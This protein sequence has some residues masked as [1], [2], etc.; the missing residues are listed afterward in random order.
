MG[1]EN[2]L[3]INF[4]NMLFPMV[5]MPPICHPPLFSGNGLHR[6]IY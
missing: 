1:L 5:A 2:G 3:K 4:Q 6:L